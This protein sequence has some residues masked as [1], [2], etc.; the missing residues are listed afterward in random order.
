MRHA[1]QLLA[2]LVPLTV[3]FHPENR[4]GIE[5][6]VHCGRSSTISGELLAVR[7]S[8]LVIC[9]TLGLD[10]QALASQPDK[11]AIIPRQTIWKVRTKFETYEGSGA[12][13]GGV[14]GCVLGYAAGCTSVS[15]PGCEA[16]PGAHERANTERRQNTIIGV[17]VGT[18][19]GTCL[20][21]FIGSTIESEG[22]VFYDPNLSSLK[23]LARFAAEEPAFLR[24]RIE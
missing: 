8:A 20:G 22:V 15:E 14:S 17:L 18:L 1:L 24:E 3:G 6:K 12:L 10:D 4:P 16:S 9:K 19:A 13:I 21:A 11:I 2:L 7:D 5:V 23:P